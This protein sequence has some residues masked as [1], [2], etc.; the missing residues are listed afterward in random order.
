MIN[1]P[2][3]IRILRWVSSLISYRFVPL[4]SN[5]ILYWTG[6]MQARDM[7]CAEASVKNLP[8]R[9]VRWNHWILQ[10]YDPAGQSGGKGLRVFHTIVWFAGGGSSCPTQKW[11]GL[12][13]PTPVRPPEMLA[14][15]TLSPTRN[16]PT[17]CN[18]ARWSTLFNP[19]VALVPATAEVR[20]GT[21]LC[22][23]QPVATVRSDRSAF[24][25]PAPL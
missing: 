8:S 11:R 12:T 24:L 17:Y 15:I 10:Q 2:S 5:A 21:I 4:C 1:P 22:S 20:R 19:S 14:M 9:E 23:T 16:P 3:V 6:T 25:W 13:S 18:L 7:Y